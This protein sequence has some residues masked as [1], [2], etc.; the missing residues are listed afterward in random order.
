[1]FCVLKKTK[2][3]PTYVSKH[4][5]DREKQVFLLMIPNGEG[6]HYIAVKQ[7]PALLLLLLL[8]RAITSKHNN[9]FYCMNCLHSFRTKNK[10]KSHKKVCENKDFS[11]IVMTS[12]DVKI[13]EFNQ[14][15]KSE[16]APFV[17]YANL[18]FSIEKVDEYKNNLE[19]LSTT[20][21][22]EH[23]SSDF[24]ISTISSFKSIKSKHG[25]YRDC[26]KKFYEFLREHAMDVINFKKKKMKL[27]TNEQK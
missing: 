20:K 25:V 14:N 10:L 11:N 5:S 13:L 23:I 7:I 18:E 21:V 19:N 16:K 27:L 15:Q 2:I 17:I 3:Y 4:S 12:E 26:M 8:L 9:D 6:W 1:M 22:G 24:S